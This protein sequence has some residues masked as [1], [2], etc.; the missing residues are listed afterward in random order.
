MKQTNIIITL[1]GG[2]IQSIESDTPVKVAV[3]DI[4]EDSSGDEKETVITNTDNS[5]FSAVVTI[6]NVTET[7]QRVTHIFNQL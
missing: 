3:L 6:H 4:D 5:K 1:E 7:P 2:I